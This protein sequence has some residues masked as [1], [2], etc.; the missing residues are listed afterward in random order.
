MLLIAGLVS[1][2]R[3]SKAWVREE[4]YEE[5][6]NWIDKRS[7]ERGTWG[8]LDEE[9]AQERGQVVR[10][11]RVVELAEIIRQYAA[12][13][14]P[15]FAAL[16]E[17]QVRAFRHQ[18]RI[19]AAKMLATIEQISLGKVPVA[20][21][22]AGE[23]LYDALKRQMLDFAYRHYPA[24]LDLDIDTIRQLDRLVGAWAE[25]SMT[26]LEQWKA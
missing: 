5:S 21:T 7:G 16:P 13:Q 6:G 8:S 22:A 1:R 18:T 19:E 11:G 2:K 20:A 23:F 17:E 24:L 15:G 4:R 12:T 25:T 10:Q 26:E 9:M 14:V 3:R